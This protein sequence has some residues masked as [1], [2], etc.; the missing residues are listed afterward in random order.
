M[1]RCPHLDYESRSYFVNSDDKYICKLNGRK[2]DIDDITVKTLCK[3][4]YGENYRN[5]PVYKLS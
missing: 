3:V 2:M 1:A 4:D 5:C